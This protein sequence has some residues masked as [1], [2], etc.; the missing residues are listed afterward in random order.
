MWRTV[1]AS[2]FCLAVAQGVAL[3]QWTCDTATP[4]VLPSGP[5]TVET[6]GPAESFGY[7]HRFAIDRPAVIEISGGPCLIPGAAIASLWSECD[8]ESPSGLV[9]RYETP[10]MEAGSFASGD[11]ELGPGVYYL[12]YKTLCVLDW[13]TFFYGSLQIDSR[14]MLEFEVISRI[15]PRSRGVAPVAVLGSE[16][17]DVSEIDVATLR[18]GPSEA[19]TKHDLTDPWTYNEHL[20]DVN[21]DGFPD[22]VAHFP[23]QDTGIACGDGRVRLA[24]RLSD[25]SQV[26][27]TVSIRTAGCPPKN[28]SNLKSTKTVKQDASGSPSFRAGS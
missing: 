28:R 16:A 27:G 12:E 9:G 15:N 2:I 26:Y 20:R 17:F 10:D 13:D 11:I 22:L 1:L 25:G 14:H 7:W 8:G 5:T 18:F 23:T 19:P 24:A 4:V 21:L 6:M 3:G